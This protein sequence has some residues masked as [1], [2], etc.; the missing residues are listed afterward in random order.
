MDFLIVRT[1]KEREAVGVLTRDELFEP[2][3][4]DGIIQNAQGVW[5]MRI[6]TQDDGTFVIL[7]R[8][9]A[10]PP[11]YIPRLIAEPVSESEYHTYKTFDLF[12]D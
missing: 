10:W 2:A 3:D 11:K 7:Q 9:N 5:I 8:N 12:A 4:Q 6:D 1:Y